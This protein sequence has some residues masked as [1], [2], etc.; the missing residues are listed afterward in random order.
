[1]NTHH[2]SKVNPLVNPV[3]AGDH[4][5]AESG[6]KYIVMQTMSGHYWLRHIR[7]QFDLTHPVDGQVAI[8]RQIYD[9]ANI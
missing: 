5:I 3:I 7:D 1:M 2:H 6:E 9:L 4:V 8:C